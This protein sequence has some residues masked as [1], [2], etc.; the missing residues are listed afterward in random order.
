MKQCKRS[1]REYWNEFRLVASEPE[2]DDLT[3]GVLLLGGMIAEL[4]NP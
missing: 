1:V 3:G 2:L 4:Q